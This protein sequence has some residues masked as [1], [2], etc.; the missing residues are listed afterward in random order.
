MK[1]SGDIFAGLRQFVK[2][3]NGFIGIER[4]QFYTVLL[5]NLM[6]LLGYFHYPRRAAADDQNG[7]L[8]GD[9]SF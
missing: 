4:F 1:G 3:L 9:Y 6:R 2:L 5:Q 7:W 8:G